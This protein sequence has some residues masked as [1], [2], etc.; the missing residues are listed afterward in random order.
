MR[1]FWSGAFVMAAAVALVVGIFQPA[2]VNAGSERGLRSDVYRTDGGNYIEIV[3]VPGFGT[4]M[5]T[6]NDTQCRIN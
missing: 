2:E 3:K 5:L 4:C 1:I 6:S